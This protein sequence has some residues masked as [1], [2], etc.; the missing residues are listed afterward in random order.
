MYLKHPTVVPTNWNEKSKR[1]PCIGVCTPDFEA[2][3]C[4]ACGQTFKELAER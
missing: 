1:S 4:T 2:E 3:K